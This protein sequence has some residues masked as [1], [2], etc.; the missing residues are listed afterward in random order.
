MKSS[1]GV[2]LVAA[3]AVIAIAGLLGVVVAALYS[4]RTASSLDRLSE[5]RAEAIAEGGME[6]AIRRYKL[7]C[8]GYAPGAAQSLGGGT[9]TI[10]LFDD[11]FSG[12]TL[13]GKK[14]IRSTGTVGGATRVVE[15]VVS[16]VT[17]QPRVMSSSTTITLSNPNATV[18]CGPGATNPC[19]QAQITAGTCVCTKEYDTSITPVVV[20]GPTPSQPPG[21]CTYK[22]TSAAWPGGVY[23]C[24]TF[25]AQ[26]ATIAITGPVTLYASSVSLTNSAQF[27]TGGSSADILLLATSQVQLGTS[28]AFTGGIYCANAAKTCSVTVSNY[29]QI[30]GFITTDVG[31]LANTADIRL[32]TQGG[33]SSGAYTGYFDPRVYWREAQP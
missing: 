19:T 16:C 31:I 2:S 22:N 26:Q 12:A 7:D 1:S 8:A 4:S 9:F 15:Q 29:A 17:P 18:Y 20:P 21:G 33:T 30:I 27:N 25:S 5:V 14:R 11:D 24:A 13:S 10:Q 6:A 28:A 3:I 23:Y 32:D